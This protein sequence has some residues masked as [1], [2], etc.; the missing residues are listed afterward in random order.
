MR[1]DRAWGWNSL[2]SRPMRPAS[3]LEKSRMSVSTCS[4]SRPDETISSASS[5]VRLV[6]CSRARVSDTATTPFSGVRSSWLILARNR[7]FSWLAA[8]SW[9]VRSRTRCSRL[10]RTSSARSRSVRSARARAPTSSARASRSSTPRPPIRAASVEAASRLSG[11]MM[12]PRATATIRA[13][14]ARAASRPIIR[15]HAA[16]RRAET[17]MA[18]LGEAIRKYQSGPVR[19][20]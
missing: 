6:F 18:D 3:I 14:W 15:I 4:S 17:M 8:S 7:D 5:R 13:D 16:E 20:P 1:A 2:I 19:K 10:A 11:L 12:V 9:A